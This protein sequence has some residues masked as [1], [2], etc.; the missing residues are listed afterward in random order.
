MTIEWKRFE[1]EV[2][3]ENRGVVMGFRSGPVWMID[4]M[5]ADGSFGKPYWEHV[6]L[7]GIGGD[8]V[9]PVSAAERWR[10]L[11]EDEGHTHWA[12]IDPP[13]DA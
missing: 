7:G 2:P 12:Y 9:S 11:A 13:E 5:F 1:D 6:L 10:E 3:A 4:A 8:E